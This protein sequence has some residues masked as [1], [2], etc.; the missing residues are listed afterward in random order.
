M[1]C[2]SSA[3]ACSGRMTS[4]ARPARR[5]T[6]TPIPGLTGSSCRAACSAPATRRRCWRISLRRARKPSRSCGMRRERL[7]GTSTRSVRSLRRSW[8]TS[9]RSTAPAKRLT[10]WRES[11][12]WKTRSMTAAVKT[13]STRIPCLRRS[14]SSFTRASRIRLL[15][16]SGR[17][18]LTKTCASGTR[19]TAA[20]GLAAAAETTITTTRTTPTTTKTGTP[21][22]PSWPT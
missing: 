12:S 13:T 9:Y 20:R 8:L 14:I 17:R 6:K 1:P 16:S 10:C 21:M 15:R 7:R 18:N 5:N 19:S 3:K 11:S 22:I 4:S 2:S